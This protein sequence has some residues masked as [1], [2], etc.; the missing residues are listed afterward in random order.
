MKSSLYVSLNLKQL[1]KDLG[2][3]ADPFMVDE[4]TAPCPGCGEHLRSLVL[5]KLKG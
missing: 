5:P 4:Y 3:H 1:L 2:D